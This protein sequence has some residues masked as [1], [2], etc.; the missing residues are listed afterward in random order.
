[1]MK[2]LTIMALLTAGS[3]Y[4]TAQDYKYLTAAYDGVERSFKLATVQKI[5]FEGDNVA[6][7]TS[8]GTTALPLNQMEK[9]YFSA[10]ATAIEAMASESKSLSVDGELLCA[11]G[12][13]T[14][15][16][17]NAGGQLVRMAHVESNMLLS[18]SSL[19][20]GV[21]IANLGDET[22]KISKQ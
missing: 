18:L 8:Q 5:T 19:P 10:E 1:M 17:Y 12:E 21:Y 6:V 22:I 15:Y 7:T 14:L 16:V 13:G 4:A 20:K 2:R 9:M 3:L 11:T